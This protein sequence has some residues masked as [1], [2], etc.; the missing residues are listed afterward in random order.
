MNRR[1]R[2]GL[3]RTT[4]T[5]VAWLLLLTIAA[6]LRFLAPDWDGGIAAHPDERY[7]LGV[8]ASVP[9]GANICA[10]APDFPYGH[11]P[12]TL[13]QMLVRAAPGHDPL[14]AARLLS[15]LVGIVG[16]AVA[17]RLGQQLAGGV[18]G[19]LAATIAT[20]SP[21][22]VQQ[23]HFYTVDPLGMTLSSGAILAAQR[24]RWELAGILGGLALA[25]KLTLVV[26]FVPLLLTALLGSRSRGASNGGVAH[27]RWPRVGLGAVCA[28]LVASPWS[29][30]T[31]R[32]CWRGPL[33]QS[34][35]AAGR[36]EL[37]YTMQYSG[38]LPYIY[39]LVQ[40]G[41]WGLGALA[42][43]LG[44]LGL[45]IATK[46]TGGLRRA[47]AVPAW[48]WALVYLS[49]VGSAV[50]KFP[51][52][53][54]PLYP[55]WAAWAAY[56]IFHLCELRR[57]AGALLGV[58]TASTTSIAGL[59]Q[60]GV[61]GQPHP[62]IVASQRLYERLE[63]GSIIGIEAWE[64]P[65]PVPLPAGDVSQFVQRTAP[66]YDDESA[67]KLSALSDLSDQ[68]DVIVIASPR[69]YGALAQSPLRFPETLGWYA[70]SLRDRS[71]E[72]YARCPRI[73]PLAFSDEPLRDA[74]LDVRL[75][76]AQICGTRWAVRLP[77]L[78]ESFRVYD[79][80]LTLLLWSRQ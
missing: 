50:T 13:A 80:P 34:L 27:P 29:L 25:C 6:W 30:L 16:V 45:L 65:L 22:L 47:L 78:D 5:Q 21:L 54:L 63:P 37:P 20:F 24:K 75:T 71:V 31:P 18:S 69:G 57:F 4:A 46:Q 12:I 79:A 44:A 77:H 76:A 52:Y 23:A 56:S 66:V 38:T 70:H 58:L 51:R 17:G 7:V 10:Y 73:G 55:V 35:M 67:Q 48:S 41:L 49:V 14:Y 64:H 15:G 3:R 26:V 8:A 72:V 36:Y 1:R 61:Y 60:I 59:A 32:L 74:G 53:M 9:L 2:L 28:F 43:L 33:L 42:T 11:L 19:L 39:P 40:M 62:W 68:A